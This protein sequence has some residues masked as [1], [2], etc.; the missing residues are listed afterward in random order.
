MPSYRIIKGLT[1]PSGRDARRT[2]LDDLIILAGEMEI[3]DAALMTSAESQ[4][5][6]V[7]LAAQGFACVTD[8]Y[9]SHRFNV[10]KMEGD[11][12]KIL[13]FKLEMPP[14]TPVIDYQ[15]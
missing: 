3:G 12:S 10:D 13:V 1:P 8:G 6:R 9:A 7:V 2:K 4:T 14:T 11:L 5:F 15:I